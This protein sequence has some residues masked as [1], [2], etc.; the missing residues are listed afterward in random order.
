M[1]AEASACPWAMF[2]GIP[3]AIRAV[4]V[5]SKVFTYVACPDVMLPKAWVN[6]RNGA[7]IVTLPFNP[8]RTLVV[9]NPD[10]CRCLCSNDAKMKVRS[11]SNGQPNVAPYWVRVNGGSATGAKALRA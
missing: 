6:G 1:A 11:R 10:S 7:P 3:E 9:K 8:E 2:A 4:A 5:V